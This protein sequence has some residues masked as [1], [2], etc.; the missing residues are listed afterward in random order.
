ME[1]AERNISEKDNEATYSLLYITRAY[2]RGEITLDEWLA[3]S[4]EW[5]ERMID[6]DKVAVQLSAIVA[7]R[8]CCN[9]TTGRGRSTP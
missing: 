4:R 5:A 1:L 7:R 3:L 9:A 2:N 8:H 6:A